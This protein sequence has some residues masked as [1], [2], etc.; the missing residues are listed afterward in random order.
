MRFNSII[1]IFILAPFFIIAQSKISWSPEECMKMKN[2]SNVRVSPDGKKVVYAVREAAMAGDRSGYVNQ[3]FLCNADG[4]N[5]IQVTKG[6][7]NNTN[8]KWSRDG[9]WVAF[10]SNRDGKNNLYLISLNGGEAEKIT[11]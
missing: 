3:V 1:A 9:N 11:D 6:D 7:K 5:T 8:P 2:I 4:S 10:I